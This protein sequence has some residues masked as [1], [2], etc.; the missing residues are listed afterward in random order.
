MEIE[1]G[2]VMLRR[3]NSEKERAKRCL[4]GGVERMMPSKTETERSSTTNFDPIRGGERDIASA[5]VAGQ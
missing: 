5:G 1:G 2:M 3:R 4:S